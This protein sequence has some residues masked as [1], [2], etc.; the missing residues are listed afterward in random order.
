MIATYSR[1]TPTFLDDRSSA[2]AEGHAHFVLFYV[3][4]GPSFRIVSLPGCPGQ[5]FLQV[6]QWPWRQLELSCVCCGRD[7]GLGTY[8]LHVPCG[9]PRIYLIEVPARLLGGHWSCTTTWCT[10]LRTWSCKQSQASPWST[11]I[12][13]F[14]QPMALIIYLYFR[15]E[16]FTRWGLGSIAIQPPF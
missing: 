13:K 15:F 16:V 1:C 2:K 5:G 4:S 12:G 6:L 10:I 3:E 14:H 7:W 8:C 9:K 11:A